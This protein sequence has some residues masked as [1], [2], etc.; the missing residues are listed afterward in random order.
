M[1]LSQK[2]PVN[3]D[4][5]R[6]LFAGVLGTLAAGLIGAYVS[7]T[8]FTG[9]GLI[10][11][12]APDLPAEATPSPSP[13]LDYELS[14]R[15][16]GGQSVSLSALR[17]HVVFLS[18][19]ASWCTPCTAELPAIQNLYGRFRGVPDVRFLLVSQEDPANLRA[20]LSDRNVTVPILREDGAL[21]RRF[22]VDAIPA[23]F[24]LDREGRVVY[25]HEGAARW[26]AE[27]VE[28]F[29]RDLR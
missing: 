15:T 5:L 28:E 17:G 27:G 20:Y 18:F 9:G 23:T 2:R 16:L 29:I 10:S 14:V 13:R 26:D 21:A 1:P 24:L 6:G 19:F 12:P 4:F 3:P 22:G 11:L 8:I 7:G 25:R